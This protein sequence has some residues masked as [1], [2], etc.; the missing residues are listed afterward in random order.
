MPPYPASPASPHNRPTEN[1]VRPT[2]RDRRVA[3][4]REL[5]RARTA[6]LVEGP[7]DRAALEALAARLGLDLSA[8]RTVVVSMG[9]ATNIRRFVERLG[10]RGLGLRLGG[11]CDVGEEHHFRAALEHSGLGAELAP[12]GFHV[13]VA[14]LEDELIRA[15]GVAGVERVVAE[16]DE[17]RSLRRFRNQPAQRGRP[18][19]QQLRRFLGTTSG[20]KIRYGRVLAEALD[21]ARIPEP[22][23]RV[24]ERG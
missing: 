20:R 14:D 2:G 3:P 12:R 15:L 17:L 24:L 9:G 23:A 10:P 11:L 19:D 1:R 13:C 22:L 21:P 6:I 18:A 8:R 4:V 5:E 16:Q 7:S